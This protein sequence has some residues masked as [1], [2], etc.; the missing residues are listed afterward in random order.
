MR[1]IFF[2]AFLVLPLTAYTTE[3]DFERTITAI[4]NENPFSYNLD[5]RYS[6]GTNQTVLLCNHGF[7][8]NSQ[9]VINRV[10]PNTSDT[11]IAFNYIDHDFS[12][13]T[14][15]DT[16][17]V[18]ATPLEIMPLI[19]ILKKLV[20]DNNISTLSLYGYALG[21][22]NIIYAI[23]ML[24]TQTHDDFL[25]SFNITESDKTSIMQ[26]LRKGTILL[27]VPFKSVEEM[28]AM[29]GPTKI[30]QMYKE[31]AAK[32]NILS[33]LDTLG[34]LKNLGV[35]FLLFFDNK[36][37]EFSNRYDSPFVKNLLEANSN[38]TNI[39]ITT[40]NGGHS[41]IHRILWRVYS[42]L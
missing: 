3:S 5:V 18:I 32:F 34:K 28:I 17:T 26:A 33:P 13:E 4:E 11:I 36:D 24:T 12:H 37:E 10:R 20:V 35:T 9:S 30:L 25:K 29:H 40:D 31:R 8:G 39:V 15:D 6:S 22:A 14:G 7:G 23:D 41:A 21:A 19:Y 16:K 1:S 2:L 42:S 38:G 27:D